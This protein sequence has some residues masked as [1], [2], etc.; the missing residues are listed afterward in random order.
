MGCQSTTAA[1]CYPEVSTS[2]KK[3]F[4]RHMTLVGARLDY[5]IIS[6]WKMIIILVLVYRGTCFEHDVDQTEKQVSCSGGLSSHGYFLN[7]IQGARSQN[8][9]SAWRSTSYNLIMAQFKCL[10]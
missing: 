6:L 8:S 10:I 4:G 5:S 7:L 2:I 9:T 1:Q 3:Y